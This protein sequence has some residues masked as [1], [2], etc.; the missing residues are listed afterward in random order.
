MK[1]CKSVVKKPRSGEMERQ[2]LLWNHNTGFC[3]FVKMT[4]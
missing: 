1:S 4:M 2:F 3:L